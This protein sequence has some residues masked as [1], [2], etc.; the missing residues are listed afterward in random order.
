MTAED[1]LI[2]RQHLRKKIETVWPEAEII[3]ECADGLSAI[4]K[5]EELAPQVCFLDIHMP[6]MTG[7]EVAR[8][9][10]ARSHIV[11]VTAYDQYAIEAFEKGAVD[12]LVKPINDERLAKTVERLKER[13]ASVPSDLSSIIA[14]LRQA[15]VGHAKEYLRWIKASQGAALKM[16][17]VSDVLFFNSDE[18]YTRVVTAEG[19]LLIRKP[20]KELTDELDPNQFWQIHRSTMVR[21]NAIEKV[22]RDFRGDAT[23]HIKGVRESLKVSRPF[24]HLFKQ[25]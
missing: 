14:S 3:A 13:L 18:K 15:S 4:E 22:T 9:A 7:L 17:A 16:I 12:Y 20:M 23:V 24:S 5:I 21:A 6:E 8:D 11:F 10:G 2:L 19:E 25:M 1:E